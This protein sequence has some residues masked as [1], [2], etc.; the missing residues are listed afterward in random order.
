M[1]IWIYG[2]SDDL[3]EVDGDTSE[4]FMAT[5]NSHDTLVV[6]PIGAVVTV[7]YDNEGMW[8]LS[9]DGEYDCIEHYGL[10]EH[11]YKHY[12]EAIRVEGDNLSVRQT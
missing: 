4:E 9:V 2:A 10:G 11:E 1:T 7:V 6:S 5:N 8:R 12:S 3:I